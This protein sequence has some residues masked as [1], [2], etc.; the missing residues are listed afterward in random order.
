[1]ATTA[2]RVYLSPDSKY[3]L[4]E[5]HYTDRGNI[6]SISP[7]GNEAD[8]V[9]ELQAAY[10]QLI[11]ETQQAFASDPITD[12]TVAEH[13]AAEQ[14]AESFGD[15]TIEPEPLENSSTVGEQDVPEDNAFSQ[16]LSDDADDGLAP[17]PTEPGDLDGNEPEPESEPVLDP[18]VTD[19]DGTPLDPTDDPT[20]PEDIG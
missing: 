7:A 18:A 12:E 6:E 14:L 3:R 17:E 2:Y 13:A 19:E 9:E 11:G 1:M 8:T 5:V 10:H 16:F 15:P 20:D 4:V